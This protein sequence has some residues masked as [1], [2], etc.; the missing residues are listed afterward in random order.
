MFIGE[1]TMY[2]LPQNEWVV[3]FYPQTGIIR[4]CPT[5]DFAKHTLSKSSSQFIYKSPS[6][7]RARHDHH[8]LEKFWV[9]AY[10]NAAWRLPR[11]ATGS[12]DSYQVTPPDTS[13]E[14]FSKLLWQMFQDIGDRMTAPTIK[15]DRTKDHYELKLGMMNDLASDEET[16]KKKY[17]NQAR[18]VFSA[19]LDN[20]KQFLSEEEI[21]IIILGLVSSHKLKTKQEPWIIFQYYRPQFIKDGFII[22]GRQPKNR[23]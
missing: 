16:Y 17:N 2:E 5:L 9:A 11:T 12:L 4:L 21:K 8:S 22:R 10:R 1:H 19:L 7:F 13:T 14:E 18:T 3:I 15:E 20:G 6:D 23:G